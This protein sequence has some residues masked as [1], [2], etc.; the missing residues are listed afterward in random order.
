MQALRAEVEALRSELSASRALPPAAN[1]ERIDRAL[2]VELLES[3]APPAR[4]DTGTDS[5]TI[6]DSPGAGDG[7]LVRASRWLERRLRGGRS[8]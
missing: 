1:A 6:A 8:S 3:Q 5:G 7:P 2:E 4:P